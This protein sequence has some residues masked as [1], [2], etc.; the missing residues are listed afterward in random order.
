MAHNN[1]SPKQ[2]LVDSFLS[3][4][5]IASGPQNICSG[6]ILNKRWII[7]SAHCLAKHTNPDELQ[8]HYGSK[9][10]NDVNRIRVDVEKIEIHPKYKRVPLINNV[11]LIKTKDDIKFGAGVQPATLPTSEA[12]EYEKV[13]AIGW[14]SADEEVCLD[15]I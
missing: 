10:R 3:A 2:K 4:V 11:A 1:K 5:S 7:T 15:R 8:V 12:R 13:Y 6:I 9:N 14:N